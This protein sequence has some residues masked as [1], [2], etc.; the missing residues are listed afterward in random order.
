DRAGRR[1]DAAAG[2]GGPDLPG[3]MVPARRGG[4]PVPARPGA[5]GR[6][7]RGGGRGADGGRTRRRRQRPLPALTDGSAGRD[8]TVTVRALGGRVLPVRGGD[9]A[10]RGPVAG[11]SAHTRRRMGAPARPAAPRGGAPPAGSWGR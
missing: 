6:G 8:R 10:G 4:A 7:A 3:G 11:N 5:R 2:G 9:R 1:S